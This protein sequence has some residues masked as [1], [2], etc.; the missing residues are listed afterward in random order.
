MVSEAVKDE[1]RRQE[2]N[3][4]DKLHG[5]RGS[6]LQAIIRKKVR[7]ERLA[8]AEKIPGVGIVFD[9]EGKLYVSWTP[10]TVNPSYSGYRTYRVDHPQ[11]WKNL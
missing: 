10:W 4:N 1:I 8:K 7:L 11:Y 3:L 6:K 2:A 9:V 5:P